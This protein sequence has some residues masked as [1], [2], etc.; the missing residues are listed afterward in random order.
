[1]CNQLVRDIR[2]FGKKRAD[3]RSSSATPDRA[4]AKNGAQIVF[5]IGRSIATPHEPGAQLVGL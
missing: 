2:T 3:L 5:D 4:K 1:M